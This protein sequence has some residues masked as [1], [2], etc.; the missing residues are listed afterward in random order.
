[1]IIAD[2]LRSPYPSPSA[3]LGVGLSVDTLPETNT[4]TLPLQPP[5]PQGGGRK[6]FHIGFGQ[7]LISSA[8]SEGMPALVLTKLAREGDG[9]DT[10]Y[11]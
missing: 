1:M 5:S 4:A 3:P 11:L 2:R 10:R 6:Y 9:G 7:Q 8:G